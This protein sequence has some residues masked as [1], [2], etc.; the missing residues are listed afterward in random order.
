MSVVEA[1]APDAP[2]GLRRALILATLTTTVALYAM[3]LTIANVSLPQMQGA[4]SGRVLYL[5]LTFTVITR[6]N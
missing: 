5:F 6:L 3:T 2:T 1:A 4:L